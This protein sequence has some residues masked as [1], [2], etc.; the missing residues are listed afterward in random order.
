[1]V[2]GELGYVHTDA[3]GPARE[4]GIILAVWAFR[5]AEP[6]AATI[7]VGGAE[8]ATGGLAEAVGLSR[9]VLLEGVEGV[10]AVLT[11]ALGREADSLTARRLHWPAGAM[12]DLIDQVRRYHDRAAS[13]DPQALAA[14]L[15]EL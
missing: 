6:E 1:H 2:P 12:S 13:Y 8:T 11:A 9:R 5:A 4:T 15:A 7:T 10:D 14:C 3:T